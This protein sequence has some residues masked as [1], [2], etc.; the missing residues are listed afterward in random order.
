M[1]QLIDIKKDYPVAG[2]VV[3]ALN[4]VSIKFRKT[5]LFQ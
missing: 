3:H 2:G 1:L 5:S 4:G